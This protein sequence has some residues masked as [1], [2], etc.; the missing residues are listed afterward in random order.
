MERTSHEVNG[1]FRQV[2]LCL[3]VVVV[4]VLGVVVVLVVVV[5]VV[6]V[7]FSFTHSHTKRQQVCLRGVDGRQ[8]RVSIQSDRACEG[9]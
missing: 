6:V 5:L 9:L 4:V 1:C 8:R 7:E 3:L 2:H